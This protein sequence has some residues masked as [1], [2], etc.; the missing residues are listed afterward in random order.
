MT[1]VSEENSLA[2]LVTKAQS[3]DRDAMEHLVA[4][5]RPRV[6]RYV[7]ARVLDPHTADD[8]TQ[9]VTVTMV[10]SLHRYVDQGRPVVAWVFG[11]A[12]NKVS[13]SRR[14]T[15][16]RRESLTELAPEHAADATLEPEQAL[17][18][19]EASAQVAALLDTLPLQQAEILRLRVAAG[20][21]AEETAAVLDMTPG[22][23][24]VAQHRALSKLRATSTPDRAS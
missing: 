2:S 19:L 1:T 4:Q 21:S 10:Q 18:R 3:G 7:L 12:A 23:V 14:A 9:E 11:I 13:E 16:R 5:I 8:V 24:R 20:L 22:A 6:F 15:G 17:L